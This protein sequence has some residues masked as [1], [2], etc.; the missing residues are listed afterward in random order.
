MHSPNAAVQ[1]QNPQGLHSHAT[2]AAASELGL[3]VLLLLFPPPAPLPSLGFRSFSVPPYLFRSVLPCCS[4][5]RLN[6]MAR[7]LGLGEVQ[8]GEGSQV[9][10]AT[11]WPQLRSIILLRRIQG[12]GALGGKNICSS[13]E[14]RKQLMPQYE[15]TQVKI[16]E[17]SLFRHAAYRHSLGSLNCSNLW[18]SSLEPI[19]RA[20]SYGDKSD[21]QRLL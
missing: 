3:R 2:A 18:S 12:P 21:Q 14:G 11:S 6:W 20:W 9:I 1:L 19:P 7:G 15:L 8:N 10:I 13:A 16:Q 5:S 4:G 17:N